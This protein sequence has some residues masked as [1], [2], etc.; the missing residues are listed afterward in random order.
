MF[1]AEVQAGIEESLRST[2][3]GAVL[4]AAGI[5]TVALNDRGEMVEHKP[6]GTSRVI[7]AP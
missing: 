2:D 4:S 5:T 6:D 3:L 7:E 1:D